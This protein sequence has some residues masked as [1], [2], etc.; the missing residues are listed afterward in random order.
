LAATRRPP[1][2]PRSP[3]TLR[4]EFGHHFAGL[5]DEYYTSDV[6]YETGVT[7]ARAVEPNITALKDPAR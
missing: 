1:W 4:H 2:T 7:I 5:G 6:A 3:T